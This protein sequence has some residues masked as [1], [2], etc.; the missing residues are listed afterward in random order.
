LHRATN[1]SISMM[2]DP[3][4]RTA[5]VSRLVEAATSRLTPAVR[6][7]LAVHSWSLLQP[8]TLDNAHRADFDAER[9]AAD[10]RH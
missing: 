3:K 6:R 10:F 8:V 5:G 1:L 2:R 9:L 7:T 4:K